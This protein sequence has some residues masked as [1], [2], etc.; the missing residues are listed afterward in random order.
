MK[1]E[2]VLEIAKTEEGVEVDPSSD[3][4]DDPD[5]A[6]ERDKSIFNIQSK[7]W[8]D[9]SYKI[10]Q[11]NFQACTIIQA[12]CSD[13]LSDRLKADASLKEIMET[14]DCIR[15]LELVKTS[16]LGYGGRGYELKNSI[17]G[18]I[19][20]LT[21]DLL[22]CSMGP[23]ES[24]RNYY[25]RFDAALLHAKKAGLKLEKLVD[26]KDL[27]NLS[28]N[29]KQ[30]QV[31]SILIIGGAD[32]SR[33]HAYKE[34]LHKKAIHGED[35]Y[36]NTLCSSMTG[37]DEHKQKRSLPT[38]DL[39]NGTSFQ[40]EG[41]EFVAGT[42]GVLRKRMQCWICNKWGHRKPQCPS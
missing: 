14:S 40:Q 9:K 22:T 25:S 12:Q 30:E 17:D 23:R 28:A 32:D 18:V 34:W 26:F 31:K 21:C 6:Y 35:C 2:I 7:L 10:E 8:T 36:P 15:L 16:S 37:L 11:Q 4:E 5:L 27:S 42:D 13:A 1:K 41:K 39:H 38:Q 20:L 19:D 3:E 29:E 24:R 33:F